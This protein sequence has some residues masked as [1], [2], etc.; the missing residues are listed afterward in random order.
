MILQYCQKVFRMIY[1][2]ML[3]I[4]DSVCFIITMFV[5]FYVILQN[6]TNIIVSINHGPCAITTNQEKSTAKNSSEL[7]NGDVVRPRYIRSLADPNL[8]RAISQLKPSTVSQL[9]GSRRLHGM[10][11]ES[12]TPNAQRQTLMSNSSSEHSQ[13]N[14]V[15]SSRSSRLCL[16]RLMLEVTVSN[17]WFGTSRIKPK[18]QALLSEEGL[19][20]SWTLGDTGQYLLCCLSV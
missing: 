15:S 2:L 14:S 11:P 17:I 1:T 7:D 4:N 5:F 10:K 18:K 12:S 13:K 8:Q 9:I 16:D 3:S 6:N 19:Q 20:I